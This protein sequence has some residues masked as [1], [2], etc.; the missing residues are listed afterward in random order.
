MK[1]KYFSSRY[2]SSQIRGTREKNIPKQTNWD[3]IVYM[4]LL[5]SLTLVI[6]YF[7]AKNTFY[8]TGDGHVVTEEIVVRAPGDIRLDKFYTSPNALVARGDTLFSFTFLNWQQESKAREDAADQIEKINL[9]VDSVNDSIL[10]KEQEIAVATSRIEYL[11]ELRQNFSDRVRLDVA[12]SLELTEVITELFNAHAQLETLETE[13]SVLMNNR[14]R[15]ISR[16]QGVAEQ[17]QHL[18]DPEGSGSEFYVAPAAGTILDLLLRESQQAFRTEDILSMIAT[19][20]DVYILSLFKRKNAR[21]L[22]PG[23][24][25]NVRFDNGDESAG[26]IRKTYDPRENLINPLHQTA[27]LGNDYVVVELIP[28]DRHTRIQ[29]LQLDRSG[30]EVYKPLWSGAGNSTDTSSVAE[31]LPDTVS[32][33]NP[34]PTEYGLYGDIYDQSLDGYS[35]IVSSL[36][37]EEIAH[38][39]VSRIKEEGYRAAIVPAVVNGLQHYRIAVGQFETEFSAAESA[40]SMPSDVAEDY[41]IRRMR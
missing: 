35:I 32:N 5:F 38:E 1:S 15:L 14:G 18:L 23:T 41:Y 27:E 29:W 28:S 11:E 6:G 36:K 24:V 16:M 17:L 31:P 8:A 3:R 37:E 12:T 9:E 4:I 22:L 20:A 19:D 39:V 10:L 30:A 13:L 26:I 21:H 25:M 34:K 40:I 33:E 7:L 2:Q